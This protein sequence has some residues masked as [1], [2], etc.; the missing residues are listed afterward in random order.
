M[1]HRM[2]IWALGLI[3]VFV[4]GCFKPSTS[5]AEQYLEDK[6]ESHYDGYDGQFIDIISFT[7]TGSRKESNGYN[8][9]EQYVIEFEADVKYLQLCAYQYVGSFSQTFQPGTIDQIKGHVIFTKY[10][11]GWRPTGALIQKDNGN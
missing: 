2:Y 5:D 9:S 8:G 11:D 6:M 7:N 10:D 4:T 3:L 1:K